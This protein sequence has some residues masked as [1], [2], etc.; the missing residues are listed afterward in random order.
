MSPWI[1]WLYHYGIGGFV[2]VTSVIILISTGALRLD[3]SRDRGLLVALVVGLLAFAALHGAWI[4][5]VVAGGSP[6]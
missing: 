3:R 4:A 5:L 6:R 2:F 1:A